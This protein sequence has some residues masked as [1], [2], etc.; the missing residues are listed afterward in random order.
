MDLGALAGVVEKG[1]GFNPPPR[2]PAVLRDISIIVDKGVYSEKIA[3]IIREEGGDMVESVALFD[4]YEGKQMAPGEKALAY[5]ICYR[6]R[7]TTLEGGKVN[8]IY[9]ATIRRI[10]METGGRLREA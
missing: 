6:S 1:A 7:E 3:D 5:R 4:L 9:D 2:F 8:L 10:V